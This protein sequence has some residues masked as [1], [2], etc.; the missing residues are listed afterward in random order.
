MS[1][2]DSWSYDDNKIRKNYH[3]SI[4]WHFFRSKL[5]EKQRKKRSQNCLRSLLSSTCGEG[6]TVYLESDDS[7]SLGQHFVMLPSWFWV[8]DPVVCFGKTQ[9]RSGM[10]KWREDLNAGLTAELKKTF[11]HPVSEGCSSK[12][13]LNL[14]QGNHSATEFI[15]KFRTV[16]ETGWPAY[17]LQGVFLQ[18][19]NDKMKDQLMSQD[20]PPSCEE[21]IL[22]A[23]C[24]DNHWR[25]REAE[26]G[27]LNWKSSA[28]V[29][30]PFVSFTHP[31]VEPPSGP[32][33]TLPEEQDYIEEQIWGRVERNFCSIVI[34]TAHSGLHPY[35]ATWRRSYFTTFAH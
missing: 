8:S 15:K 34:P 17:T 3:L 16:V 23:L 1:Y 26:K 30:R 27:I 31:S 20:E 10:W 13:L 6:C 22:L 7:A 4:F 24:I 28:R 5:Q 11:A 14:R 33:S 19:V 9:S 21:L 35:T 18:V 2:C 12:C 32:S 25:E 29:S